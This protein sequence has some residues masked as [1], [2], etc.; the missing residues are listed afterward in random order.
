MSAL[1]DFDPW[2]A[3]DKNREPTS[4]P[5]KVAKAAK[6]VDAEARRL[7]PDDDQTPLP[8]VPSA[9]DSAFGAP[10]SHNPAE[11][12]DWLDE[13]SAIREHLGCYGRVDADSLAYG[14]A[15]EAWLALFYEPPMIAACAGCGKPMDGAVLPLGD[16]TRVCDRRD[17]ACLIRYGTARK[18]RGVG[19]LRALGIEPPRG[20]T[21]PDGEAP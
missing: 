9:S 6:A 16:G 17:H 10:V 8:L 21:L 1:R 19:G 4:P 14:E 2:A 12:R 20:W 13:R 11:W 15:V 18:R 5:A 3:L 7:D